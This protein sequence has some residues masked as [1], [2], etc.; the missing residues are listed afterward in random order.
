MPTLLLVSSADA[1][2]LALKQFT[3]IIKHS[4]Q[5]IAL[6]CINARKVGKEE[7]ARLILD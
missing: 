6:M 1:K 4:V 7:K 2:I 3:I 5:P